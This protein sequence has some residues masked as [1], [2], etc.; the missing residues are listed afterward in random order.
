ML[1]F[2][3]TYTFVFLAQMYISAWTFP[4]NGTAGQSLIRN[5]TPSVECFNKRCLQTSQCTDLH[6]P[7][8][9]C[10]SGRCVCSSGFREDIPSQKCVPELPLVWLVVTLIVTF[11]IFALTI[12]WFNCIVSDLTAQ[13]AELK[14]AY[15]GSNG[16]AQESISIRSISSSSSSSLTNGTVSQCIVVM[17]NYENVEQQMDNRLG[18]TIQP[19]AS[20]SESGLI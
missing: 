19:D 11:I 18:E 6:C 7:N 8:T 20:Q 4:E 12:V 2:N 9:V 1:Y 5:Q 17:P 10:I 3:K 16:F 15:F 13:L 14:Q